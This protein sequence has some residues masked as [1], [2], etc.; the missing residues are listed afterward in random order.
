MWG[1]VQRNGC[2]CKLSVV[3][4]NC[5]LLLQIFKFKL[6]KL[7]EA[8]KDEYKIEDDLCNLSEDENEEEADVLELHAE[9]ELLGSDSGSQRQISMKLL[10]GWKVIKQSILDSSYQ[11]TE[12]GLSIFVISAALNEPEV[13][14]NGGKYTLDPFTFIS[15]N[16]I[17]FIIEDEVLRVLHAQQQEQPYLA[18][19][20][21]GKNDQLQ[22]SIKK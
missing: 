14:Q 16:Y 22:P 9:E 13:P 21:Q 3:I 5:R 12:T 8:K 18:R 10:L 2:Y 6:N 1:C 20:Q 4:E 7:Q 15:I 11:I 19:H 17:F